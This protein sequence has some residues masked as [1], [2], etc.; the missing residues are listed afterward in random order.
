MAREDANESL[1]MRGEMRLG[2]REEEDNEICSPR[3]LKLQSQLKSFVIAA[4]LTL[5]T[6]VPQYHKH[7]IIDIIFSHFQNVFSDEQN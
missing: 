6:T 5:N 7:N 2:G 3:Q 4:H 1:L